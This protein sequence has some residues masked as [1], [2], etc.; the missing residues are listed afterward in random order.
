MDKI[1]NNFYD[2][3]WSLNCPATGIIIVQDDIN[4]DDIFNILSTIINNGYDKLRKN[5]LIIILYN[6]QPED[7]ILNK[8]KN[9]I[10]TKIPNKFDIFIKK[11]ID[12][13][14]FIY[15][16]LDIKEKQI[17]NYLLLI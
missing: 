9:F 17:N 8:Y 12:F 5:G 16:E 1:E 13:P 15:K 4:E 14:Y 6:L 11:Y 7:T 10:D 3:I 2:I